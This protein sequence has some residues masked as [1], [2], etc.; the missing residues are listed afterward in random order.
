MAAN[1]SEVG[2]DGRG[3]NDVF[4]QNNVVFSAV[5]KARRLMNN[6]DCH[7]IHDHGRPS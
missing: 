1:A 6:K 5:N 4:G 3:G 2:W 7:I